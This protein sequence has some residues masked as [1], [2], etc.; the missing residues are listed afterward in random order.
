[1]DTD[2]GGWTYVVRGSPT[3]SSGHSVAYGSVQTDPSVTARWSI[4]QTK[5]NGLRSASQL[6]GEAYFEYYVSYPARNEF[7]VFRLNVADGLRFDANYGIDASY[8]STQTGLQVRSNADWITVTYT[9]NEV[10]DRG[11]IWEPGAQNICCFRS[12]DDFTFYGCAV[13]AQNAQ[14]QFSH[15]NL[16][17]HMR[18]GV[19][20]ST[21]DGLLLF[22][23]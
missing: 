4:G 23:R 7:R 12:T 20:D 17:Q 3:S 16:N 6:S 11:P 14:G 22:V 1:M 19:S 13:A 18:C 21:N 9:S 15:T 2:G 5:I 10:S 8:G